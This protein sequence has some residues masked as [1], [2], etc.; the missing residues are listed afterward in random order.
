V[1]GG[2]LPLASSVPG[3]RLC[4]S[5]SGSITAL[6]KGLEQGWRLSADLRREPSRPP[7]GLKKL[8]GTP[9]LTGAGGLVGRRLIASGLAL[10]LGGPLLAFSPLVALAHGSSLLSSRS[11]L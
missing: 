11:G 7:R 10:K 2:L 1:L 6:F 5:S 9:L 8:T 3:R 4:K